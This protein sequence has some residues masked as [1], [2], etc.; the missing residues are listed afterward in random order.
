MKQKSLKRYTDEKPVR[1]SVIIQQW[2][3]P[4][5]KDKYLVL[6][7]GKDDLDVFEQLFK[8]DKCGF[9]DCWGCKRVVDI[10]QE[11]TQKSRIKHISILDSDFRRV[12][13]DT[14]VPEGVFLTDA[15]DSE[16]LIANDFDT[17]SKASV[18]LDIPS[19]SG[20]KSRIEGELKVLSMIRWY[21]IHRKL[22]FADKNLD[23][24]NM[25]DAQMAS[26]ENLVQ[27]FNPTDGSRELAFPIAAFQR[28]MSENDEANLDQITNGHD[29]VS[30]WSHTIRY[31]H[32][33]QHADK[34]IRAAMC[35]AYSSL[36]FQGTELYANISSYCN[37]KHWDMLN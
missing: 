34:N 7:E 36:A 9:R 19:E 35:N 18:N 6:V 17:M 10:H 31:T 16:M 15:H 33:K 8:S 37:T 11:I 21:N 24:V 12:E 23:I 13:G 28:F 2:K 25:T 3:T 4:Q 32:H 14:A 26:P 29:F 5:N 20:L 27:Y 1:A 22:C 30:R